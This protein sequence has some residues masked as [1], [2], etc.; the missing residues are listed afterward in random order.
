MHWLSQL[1]NEDG[2]HL[3]SETYRRLL[4]T[5]FANP[6]DG[7]GR[8]AE[9]PLLD[10]L[11]GYPTRY[12]NTRAQAK[13]PTRALTGRAHHRGDEGSFVEVTIPDKAKRLTEV[14]YLQSGEDHAR[15]ILGGWEY[16]PE[17]AGPPARRSERQGGTRI[18]WGHPRKI[19]ATLSGNSH[20]YI[21]IVS[22]TW[23]GTWGTGDKPDLGEL[24]GSPAWYWVR[25]VE[26][27]SPTGEDRAVYEHT[28]E[29]GWKSSRPYGL[30]YQ[31]DPAVDHSQ[32]VTVQL[33]GGGSDLAIYDGQWGDACVEHVDG[34]G[35]VLS[36]SGGSVKE[37]GTFGS[38]AWYVKG[39]T[40]R[41]SHKE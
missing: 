27:T 23:G 21:R 29:T 19:I 16:T 31:E 6:H 38:G 26:N 24:G 18:T 2:A 36:Y 34:E 17:K 4:S 10:P 28:T 41:Y 40:M 3:R 8:D 9:G 39:G 25:V 33:D 32:G 11:R 12:E 35:V 20:A 30:D 13:S 7:G 22:A 14:V 5:T 37:S 15:S 1:Y